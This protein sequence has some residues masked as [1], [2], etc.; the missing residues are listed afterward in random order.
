MNRD[1]SGSPIGTFGIAGKNPPT[2]L[3]NVSGF[4]HWPAE[5]GLARIGSFCPA[6]VA[7]LS[8]CRL[9]AG[10]I[11]AVVSTLVSRPAQPRHLRRRQGDKA[12][13]E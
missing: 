8:A 2:K 7:G 3:H 11:G 12:V 4:R 10:G 1:R 9:A 6:K 5:P 13:K